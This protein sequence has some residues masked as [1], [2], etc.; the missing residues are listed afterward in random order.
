VKDL[1]LCFLRRLCTLGYQKA[2][3][4]TPGNVYNKRWETDLGADIARIRT[5]YN[6]VDSAVFPV[7]AEEPEVP[8]ISRVG[9]IDPIKDLVKL[10]RA[11]SLVIRGYWAR[12]HATASAGCASR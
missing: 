1:C 9:R 5:A 7:L 11:F 8:T 10:L 3:V 12:K 4:I 2:E 6:G